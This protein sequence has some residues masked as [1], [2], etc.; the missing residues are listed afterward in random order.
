MR[1]VVMGAGGVGGY[2]G[3]RLV[4]AGND[5]TFVA[6]GPHGEAIRRKG[7][8]AEG[9]LGEFHVQPAKCVASPGRD[10]RGAGRH[11]ICGQTFGD[12]I[13]RGAIAADYRSADQCIHRA[14]RG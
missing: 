9:T 8:R 12:G 1:I 11:S 10:R 5:V 14:E 2:F 6:R 7:L 3:G 13:C 4:L